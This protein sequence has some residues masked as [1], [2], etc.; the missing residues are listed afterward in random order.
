[1]ILRKSPPA[2][3]YSPDSRQRMIQ[4]ILLQEHPRWAALC[5][6]GLDTAD[7]EQVRR[8]L[9]YLERVERCA[10]LFIP[11][12]DQ[13]YGITERGGDAILG[14][15][16]NR[17][18]SGSYFFFADVSG[19]T[20]LLTF[21]TDRFGKEEAGDIMNLSILNRF[22]LNKMGL[23]FE[24]L[25]GSD[26][27]A[28]RGVATLKVMLAIRASMPLITEQV[29][30]E[31]RRKLAGKPH[32][33]EIRAFIEKLVVKASGGVIFDPKPGSAFY[34]EAV[35]ARITWGATGKR[36][37][38]AEKL[39]GND[40]QVRPDLEEVK[41]FAVDSVSYAR[42][43]DLFAQGW[44]GLTP[45]DLAVSEPQEGFRKVVIC[46][47]GMDKLV[48]W[49]DRACE[50]GLTA[51][52]GDWSATEGMTATDI[53]LELGGRFLE[54]ERYLGSRSLLLHVVRNLGRDGNTNL[55]LDESCSAV[56]DSG[57]LFVNFA[58]DKPEELLDPLADTIHGVMLRY[59]IL[60]KYNIFPKGDFNL[61]G[62]LGTMAAEKKESDRY[63]TEILWN[64]WRDLNRE[65][66]RQFG[67]RV[68]LRGG[69][70]V[71]K[72]LQ[73]P[74]G[75]NIIHNEET[76]IGPDCN[77]AARLV[78]EAL[79]QDQEHRFVHAPGTL[80]TIESH[81]RKVDH[82]IQPRGPEREVKLKGFSQPVALFNLT[83]RS[84]T[85]SVA[86]F[87]AR[88]RRL[89]LVTYDGQ[90]VRN[91]EDMRRGQ[92]ISRAMEIIEK[93]AAGE[94]ER[95]QL[96]AFIAASGVGKT[97]RI[98][99]LA[100]WAL[101]SGWPVF[102]GE[103]YSWYQGE[104]PT[105]GAGV[106]ADP[107]MAESH[108]DEGAYPFF[109]FIRILKEQVFRID[110]QDPPELRLDKIAQVLARL[111]PEL[112]VQAPVIASFI[113]VEAPESALSRALDPEARRN[114]FYD[115][116]ADI[117]AALVRE[118]AG[119]GVVLLC[120]D[121]LQWADRNSLHLLGYL[122]RRVGPGLVICVNARHKEQLGLLADPALPLDCELLQ[123][124]LLE[125]Q[126]VDTLARITL[127]L[128]PESAGGEGLPAVLREKLQKEL[129]N[130]PFFIIEF[131][132]KIQE[133]EI[134]RVADG[135]CTG[136]DAEQ[137]VGVTIPNK[138]QGVIEERLG[139]LP[140]EEHAAIQ[141]SSVLGNILRYVIIRQFL[142]AV[143]EGGRLFGDTKL[144]ELFS[145]LTGQEITRLENE[146]DP[147]WVYTF[148][149]A[150][151][152]EKLYQELVPSLRKRLHREVARVFESTH[153][154]NQFER[155]LMTALHYA[156]AEVPDK[157]C[158][159]YLEAGRLAR[160]VFDN[161]RSLLLF[162]RAERILADYE[163][164]DAA[165]RR[166]VLHEERGQVNQLLGRYVD[167]LADYAAL[168]T[169]AGQASDS[170]L[171]SLALYLTAGALSQRAAPGDYSAA[172]QNFE[173]AA[174]TTRDRARL[175]AILNDC[176]RTCLE[177]GQRER[178]L[179][180]LDRA[181]EAF[182]SAAGSDPTEALIFRVA[183]LRNRGS[184][185]H[186]QGRFSQALEI[187]HQ[188]LE[189]VG[190]ESEE[191]F[192]KPRA[193]LFNSVG[194]SLMKA[195]RLEEARG[196]L[197]KALELAR[198]I[199]DLKTEVM[200]R[201]NMAVVAND[202]GRADEALEL[203]S[204]EHSRLSA[205]VGDS[206][207]LAAM[208]FNIGE[209]YMFLERFEE[210]VPWYA[211]ALQVA[212]RI[213]YLEFEAATR[214]N[215]GEVL[216]TLG[217]QAEALEVL[218]PAQLLADSGG[219]DLQRMDLANLLGEIHRERGELDAARA[220]HGKALEIGRSLEDDFG[221]G[222]ALRNLAQDILAQESAPDLAACS[223]MLA[224]SVEALRRAGQPENLMHSLREMILFRLD[225]EH[226]TQ[227]V[228]ELL[229]EL[230]GLA[231][232]TS[233]RQFGEFCTAIS[234]RLG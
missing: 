20:A 205:L 229:D 167:A 2:P 200:V 215:L 173:L 212:G 218:E 120:I 157:A 192:K 60:Y 197:G 59:G 121:D 19:F 194:L 110:N 30:Q 155:V 99:E 28:D 228:K 92:F 65:V 104:G 210:A 172:V 127:G 101:E 103:C 166:R 148:K 134:I 115:R 76:I 54:I 169:L 23:L 175:A 191:R 151:I 193:Q 56:R 129:E 177:L 174:E 162:G 63:Y 226:V 143:D 69:L 142:P 206:R 78:N 57:V 183:L 135:R 83:E 161:E 202:M 132:G 68:E 100:N 223:A 73:G 61:M 52:E 222:W 106:S 168:E 207:E 146:R 16:R 67:G 234:E 140:A 81:R 4:D 144:E 152:G 26:G 95:S 224:E 203:L 108:N 125:P 122:A 149:R 11:A 93:A 107:A 209:S 21:L 75:D 71:G 182:D 216:H 225:R 160:S 17:D 208:E 150:L 77:L 80:F 139:R 86:D 48:P 130:N 97:R 39:G 13:D 153:L 214:Y 180:L 138:I 22:C 3:Q 179:G 55:L 47:A 190:N 27:S 114:V 165:E 37:A 72:A 136:F 31:L 53:L 14:Y 133:M 41:G 187:Y 32:Q 116:T 213:Q 46:P 126:A 25:Q 217:R 170:E 119:R 227:G 5:R 38:Q 117:F 50:A 128:D 34:G 62:V 51:A 219:W 230:R 145:R 9:T 158:A 6:E 196:W 185:L 201:I 64:A 35:R 109:P 33:K 159:F 85:E 10:S 105:G 186:R 131:C 147:E 156:N 58:L 220:S 124:P 204:R 111:D 102:F 94:V 79:L 181:G 233:N 91:S 221:T 44:L 176:A 15:L 184:V 178:A 45:D 29:R 211:R 171:K 113:G 49:V 164:V 199:G 96:I 40:D 88:L 43:A 8:M 12:R 231:D 24:L 74:A 198:S 7:P 163:I 1:M 98:S 188:A 36:V 195:F 141:Y 82:L 137:F 70:S 18:G 232:K 66:G 90:V 123:P 42:L 112:A 87:I 189:L 89:P 84:R 154:S 118:Q